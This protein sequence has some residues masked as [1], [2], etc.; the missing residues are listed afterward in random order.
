M[1][2]NLGALS[3]GQRKKAYIAFAMACN[4][5]L[6]LLDEPTNG[7]DIS[8]KRSFR[9]AVAECMND[10]KI[11]IISTHQVHDIDKILDRVVIMNN[12]GV[13]L[14]ES[15]DKISQKYKFSFTTDRDR[16][17]QAIISLDVPGGYNIAEPLANPDE[18]TE[19]NLETL[20]EMV[21]NKLI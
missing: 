4:T 6:L 1:D 17:S 11:I 19:V 12:R 2:I 3:M 8:S 16:A 20:F 5:S 18:E 21:T 10:D 9:R 7:L 15:L 14:D 13:L